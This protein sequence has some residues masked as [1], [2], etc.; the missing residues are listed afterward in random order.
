MKYPDQLVNIRHHLSLYIP[1]QDEIKASFEE[2]LAKDPREAFPFW[3]KIWP[4]S[5]GLAEFLLANLNW[6]KD[7]H[8][9]EI[10]AGIGMPSFNIADKVKELI[11]SDHNIDAVTCIEKNIDHLGL[12]NTIAMQLDWNNFPEHV[13]ADTLLLSDINYAPDQFES[14]LKLARGLLNKGTIIILSTPQRIMGNAFISA[15][16]PYIKETQVTTIKEAE[17]VVEISILV[18]YS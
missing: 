17:A 4:S 7:K 10:G 18:L 16:Q 14:L 3:A 1:K 9:L 8:V 6:I 5:I 15:L 13:S 11:I 12:Q 2:L